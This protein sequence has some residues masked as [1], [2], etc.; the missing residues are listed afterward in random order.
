[1]NER[2]ERNLERRLRYALRKQDCRLYKSRARNWTYNNQQGYLI[3]FVP[4]N[5]CVGGP[6]F[7]FTL[8]DVED[9]VERNR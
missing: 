2:E 9:F 7:D 8:E 6:N 1:M 3:V 4:Y 5:A